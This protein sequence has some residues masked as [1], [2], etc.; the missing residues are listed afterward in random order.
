MEVVI[1]YSTVQLLYH[2]IIQC[3]VLDF[4]FKTIRHWLDMDMWTQVRMIPEN[5]VVAY[6]KE[7]DTQQ[8]KCLHDMSTIYSAV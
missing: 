3:V 1:L 6:S 8:R 4:S 2:S 7:R 5:E